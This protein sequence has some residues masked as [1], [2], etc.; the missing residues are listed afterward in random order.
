MFISS[1]GGHLTQLLQLKSI[2]SKY[3]YVLITEKTDVTKDMKNKYNISYLPYGSRNQKL[4]YPFVLLA[5]CFMSLFYLIK[6]V[7]IS[8]A[9]Y[10]MCIAFLIKNKV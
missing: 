7:F 6:Y 3:D 9:L 10:I 2:F 1:V 4:K 8:D 5:N